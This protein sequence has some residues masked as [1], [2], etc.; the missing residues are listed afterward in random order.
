MTHLIHSREWMSTPISP[1]ILHLLSPLVS[2]LGVHVCVS[3][4]GLQIG[5]SVLFF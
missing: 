3:I 2:G 1:F 5:L 4:S